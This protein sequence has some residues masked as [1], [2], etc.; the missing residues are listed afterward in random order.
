MTRT[1][2]V[3]TL[4]GT[5]AAAHAQAAS[6]ARTDEWRIFDAV[7]QERARRGIPALQWN[8]RLAEVARQHS[9]AMATRGFFSHT[10][11]L[12]GDLGRRLARAKV[13]YTSC[14]ENIY[15]QSGSGDP[16]RRALEG[17]LASPGHRDAMLEPDF[18]ETGLGAASG[19][20]NGCWITQIFL[21]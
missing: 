11:P 7:N 3:L 9:V 19:P 1:G 15:R 6:R 5:R 17:W 14:A 4:L 21:A 13:A 20:R 18:R 12:R 8:S 16:A 2:F 10:D